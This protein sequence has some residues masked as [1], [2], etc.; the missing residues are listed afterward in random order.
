MKNRKGIS[1]FFFLGNSGDIDY[2]FM[3]IFNE[4]L[5][6]IILVS[7]DLQRVAAHTPC[8]LRSGRR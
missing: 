4:I 7:I 6:D 2:S 5:L 1:E 3:I 8:S